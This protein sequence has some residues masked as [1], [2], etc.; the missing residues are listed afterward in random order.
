M[1]TKLMELLA[2]A[3]LAL[4]FLPYIFKV[5]ELDL[6]LVLLAGLAMPIYDYLRNR[7]HRN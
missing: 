6:A 5:K 4:F 1:S 7:E 3:L 2:L